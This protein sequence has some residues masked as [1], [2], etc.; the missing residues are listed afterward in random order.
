MRLGPRTTN[1][2]AQ[3][4]SISV[5]KPAISASTLESLS[6]PGVRPCSSDQI[7][8]LPRICTLG[9][10]TYLSARSSPCRRFIRRLFAPVDGRL[11]A[12]NAFA[13]SFAQLWEFPGAE[14]E[15]GNSQNY[16]Q[17][18]RLKKSFHYRYTSFR[19]LLTVRCLKPCGRRTVVA[20]TAPLTDGE[21]SSQLHA[22]R[23]RAGLHLRLPPDHGDTQRSLPTGR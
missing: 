5:P 21:A 7:S 3:K 6:Q 23:T 20:D 13:D 15:Q 18:H 8:P 19:T 22:L 9:C 1:P 10:T 14:Y 12:P 16:E 11:E 17:M 4:S 2:R